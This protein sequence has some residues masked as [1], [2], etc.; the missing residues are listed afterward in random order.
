MC[1]NIQDNINHGTGVGVKRSWR[2]VCDNARNIWVVGGDD[3]FSD[4]CLLA[5]GNGPA[6][7][8]FPGYGAK[9]L[10][11]NAFAAHPSW[12]YNKRLS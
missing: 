7:R 11:R 5:T 10:S 1:K 9:I 8:A 3:H 4:S 6:E 2:I 12:N